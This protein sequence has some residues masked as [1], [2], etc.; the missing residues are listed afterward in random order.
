MQ[1]YEWVNENKNRIFQPVGQN[2][3]RNIEKYNKEYIVPIEEIPGYYA[4]N[5]RQVQFIENSIK[6]TFDVNVLSRLVCDLWTDIAFNNL[7]QEGNGDFKAGKKPKKL[8]RRIINMSSKEGDYILDSFLGSGSTAAVAN[9]M[10]RKWIGIEQGEHCY[11][12]CI[13]RLKKMLSLI[14][15]LVRQLVMVIQEFL[16]L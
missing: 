14:I 6:S 10:N 11:T 8:I 9:K 3:I 13:P 2:R 1:N 4:Y 5:G 15:R 7:F 12:H 16:M